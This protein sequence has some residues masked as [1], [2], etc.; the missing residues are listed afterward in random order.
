MDILEVIGGHV[1]TAGSLGDLQPVDATKDILVI[2][3]TGGSGAL[4]SGLFT[5]RYRPY[6][7]Y[8]EN[9]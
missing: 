5:V 8:G 1:Q 9:A 4:T 3:T 2:A 6:P 7:V